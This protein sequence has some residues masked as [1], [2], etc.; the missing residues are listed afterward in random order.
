MLPDTI[1]LSVQ[2]PGRYSWSPPRS[3]F[4]WSLRPFMNIDKPS[5]LCL[6]LTPWKIMLAVSLTHNPPRGTAQNRCTATSDTKTRREL[7]VRT[8]KNSSLIS[9]RVLMMMEARTRASKHVMQ[10]ERDIFLTACLIS[11]S[12]DSLV[13]ESCQ[14]KRKCIDQ[15]RPFAPKVSHVIHL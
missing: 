5:P 9:V 4:L 14:H 15:R 8:Y 2:T 6:M 12:S 1:R 13:L 7:E 10:C 3:L 11:S